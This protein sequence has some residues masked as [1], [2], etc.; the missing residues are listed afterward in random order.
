MAGKICLTLGV[1][2]IFSAP[3]NFKVSWRFLPAKNMTKI[4]SV[5]C[6]Q[7]QPI[8]KDCE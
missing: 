2:A 6:G 8:G 4:I 7:R 5:F 3:S 1:P